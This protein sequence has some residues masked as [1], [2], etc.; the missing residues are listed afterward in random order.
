MMRAVVQRVSSASVAVGVEEIS[1]IGY[2]LLVLLAAK[3]GDEEAD[4]VKLASRVAHLRI[5]SDDQGKMNLSA[6][7]SNAEILVV[8]QFTL[9]AETSKGRRPSFVDAAAPDIAEPL[10][11]T[12]C[13]E[14]SK[15]GL[16]TRS[17]R[18]RAHMSVRSINDGPVTVI[19][20]TSSSL[21]GG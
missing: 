13:D 16:S 10:I 7:D 17:G 19:M 20:E 1:R 15:L 11:Q 21:P 9:Y 2:G 14:M 12:F 8:S 18:F 3:D 4:A 5:F 6:K